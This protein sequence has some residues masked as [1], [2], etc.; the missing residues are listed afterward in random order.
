M[1]GT[2]MSELLVLRAAARV[3]ALKAMLLLVPIVAMRF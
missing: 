3:A 2:Y 1:S